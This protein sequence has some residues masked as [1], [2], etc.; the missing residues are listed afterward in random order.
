MK[1][2]VGNI[3]RRGLG[4]FYQGGDGPY[5]ILCVVAMMVEGREK[6]GR[7]KEGR[8]NEKIRIMREGE[9]EPISVN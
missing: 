8:K 9:D 4:D 7:G 5:I 1:S 3:G 2:G 6:G